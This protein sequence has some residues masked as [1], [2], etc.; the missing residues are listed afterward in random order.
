VMVIGADVTY[1]DFFDEFMKAEKLLNRS[2]HAN[3]VSPDQWK[4][5][6]AEKSAFFTKINAQPKIFVVGSQEDLAT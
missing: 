1:S 6:L 5:K 4:R 3:F 2:I